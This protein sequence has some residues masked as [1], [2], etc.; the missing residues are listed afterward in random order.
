MTHQ[1]VIDGLILCGD[2]EY[3]EET[4]VSPATYFVIA[5][6]ILLILICVL[7][8]RQRKEGSN[9]RIQS[10]LSVTKSNNTECFEI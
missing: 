5:I 8:C 1:P 4:L 6:L 7:F 2:R 9:Q 10:L 3:E